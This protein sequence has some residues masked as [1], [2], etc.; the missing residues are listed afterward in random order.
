MSAQQASTDHGRMRPMQAS[1]LP[2]VLVWRNHPEVRRYMYHRH[3]IGIDE[4]RAWFE[5][6]TV[7]PGRHLLIYEEDGEQRG[8]INLHETVTGESADWGFYAAPDAPKGTGRRLGAAALAYAFATLGL[9][10]LSG[11]ALVDNAR[12]IALHEYLGFAREGVL[13]D[14]HLDGERHHDVMCF[15]LRVDDWRERNRECGR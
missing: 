1:D 4:H 15:G 13:R 10:K 7:A 3:L 12:S 8:F 2:I 14:H 6:C 9:H 11:Q 5:R